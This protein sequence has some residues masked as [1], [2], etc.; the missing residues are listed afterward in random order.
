ML[1]KMIATIPNYQSRGFKR[2]VARVPFGEGSKS[3][4]TL[5]QMSEQPSNEVH[6]KL[7]VMWEHLPGKVLGLFGEDFGESVE[8]ANRFAQSLM[9]EYDA[10]ADKDTVHRVARQTLDKRSRHRVLLEL[11]VFI[12]ILSFLS[13]YFSK[14]SN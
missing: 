12:I 13:T 3:I 14:H 6:F 7:H 4:A 1:P 10:I 8:S 9:D 11:K 2:E 5:R